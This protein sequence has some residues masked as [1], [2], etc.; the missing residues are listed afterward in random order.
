MLLLAPAVENDVFQ[1]PAFA[2]RYHFPESAFGMRHLHIFAS[3]ADNVLKVAFATSEFDR[4]LGFAG[5]ES[6]R[7]LKSLSNRVQDLLADRFTFQ[8]HDFSPQSATIINEELHAHAHS[9][10]WERQP[11]ADYYANFV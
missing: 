6:M 1:R 3:R 5:P 11:Q 10:Y 2:D 8:I 9:D 4:A 7:P